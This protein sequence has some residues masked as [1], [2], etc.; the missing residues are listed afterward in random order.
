MAKRR[1]SNTGIPGLSFSWKRAL[2][3]TS[4]KRKIARFTG[5]PTT[6]SGRRAKA[7]R[8][9]GCATYIFIVMMIVIALIAGAVALAENESST[10]YGEEILF[11]DLPWLIDAQTFINT[12]TA[13]ACSA[14]DN[15][16]TYEGLV[17]YPES[18]AS[19]EDEVL[20]DAGFRFTVG[21][22]RDDFLVAGYPVSHI[23]ITALYGVNN[24]VVSTEIEDSKV[25]KAGYAFSSSDVPDMKA[26]FEDLY[27]K[28]SALYGNSSALEYCDYADTDTQT[29][30]A[31]WE[32][33][34]GT[35]VR[36]SGMW[37]ISDD[38]F[39]CTTSITYGTLKAHDLANELLNPESTIDKASTD[40]L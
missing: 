29:G 23:S 30:F 21:S 11:R 36:L 6:R 13:Q 5:I 12:V 18:A 32:G 24:G 20:S 2:G 39:L 16:K 3:V 37:P 4:A 26:A 31:S 33:A 1:R 17:F 19:Q 28:L 15:V 8:L 14:S 27:T 25:V 10:V 34:N 38:D 35:F 7:G 40:G 9:M 22:I